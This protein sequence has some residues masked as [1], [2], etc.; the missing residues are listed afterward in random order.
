MEECAAALRMTIERHPSVRAGAG[1]SFTIA[2]RAAQRPTSCASFRRRGCLRLTQKHPAKLLTRDERTSG[3]AAVRICNESSSIRGTLA[4][5]YVAA[6]GLRS[7][8]S[9]LRFH[10]RTPLGSGPSRI[11][12]RAL[13]A[14]VRDDAGMT[15][16]HLPSSMP[17]Q[18][19]SREVP[20]RSWPRFIRWGCRA[21]GPS[22]L[23]PW[24][25]RGN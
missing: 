23:P 19:T 12:R 6:R 17:L 9:S 20:A 7:D 22:G 4:E 14:A 1:G 3:A 24:P 25:C 13:I 18:R 21:A 8:S 10:P 15:G 2:S 5:R 11:C 16:I